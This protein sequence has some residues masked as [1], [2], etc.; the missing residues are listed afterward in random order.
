[1]RVLAVE[2][3][4]EA[5][6]VA[7]AGRVTGTAA[8]TILAVRKKGTG[9][10]EERIKLRR[11][12]VCE[13]LT[14]RPVDGSP[15]SAAMRYGAER[16]PDA[17]RAYAAAA[18]LIPKRVGFVAHDSMMVGCSPD[19]YVGPWTGVIELKCPDMPT[20]L[21]YLTGGVIPEEYRPQLLHNLW[22]TGAEW[23]DFV[24]FDDRFPPDLKLFRRR[25]TREETKK[26]IAAYELAVS[27][28]LSEVERDLAAVQA[29]RAA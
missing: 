6:H 5:W 29:L 27:L 16:E 1:M 3:R 21:A 19:G 10:L 15:A 12:L 25:M 23:I 8:A 11:R 9:E 13:R 24:S 14:G 22:V 4:S 26:E 7:R 18:G 20:H 2:Q 17:F 28:F